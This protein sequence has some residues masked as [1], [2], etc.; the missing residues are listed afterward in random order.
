MKLH[1]VSLGVLALLSSLATHAGAQEVRRPY[2]VQLAD[3][4]AASYTGGV[5][6]LPATKPAP[7]RLLSVT[8]SDVQAY[9][10]YLERK[11]AG[12]L[13][14]VAAA[15]LTHKYQLVF[16]GFAALLTDSELRALRKDA[17][18]AAIAADE[19]REPVT[20][21]TP[22]FLGLDRVPGGLWSQLGG[23]SMAG[24]GIVIGLIDTGIWPEN[25]SFADR[26]LPDGS[27]SFDPAAA[28]AYGAPPAS[29]KGACQAGEG[30]TAAHCNNKLIGAR[31]FNAGFL[32]GGRTLHWSDFVS[33]RDS[34]GG[35][36]AHGGHGTHTASTAGGNNGVAASVG[37]IAMGTVS[38]M[39]PHARLAMYKV[40][41]TF[42]EEGSADGTGS[43]N[44]CYSSDSVA[45]IESAVADGVNVINYSISGSQTSVLDP[46]EIAFFG[47][48]NAGVFV[49]ASA[50]NSGPANAVSHIAPWLTTVAAGTH[51][52]LNA[53]KA[54]TG[55]GASYTGASLNQHALTNI[56]AISAR[57]AGLVP[58]ASLNLEDQVARTLCFTAADRAAFGGSPAAALDPA[59]ASGKIV[60]CE[61]GSSAR[62]D[63][64]RAVA[65]AGG[66]GMVLAD[67]GGGLVAEVHS[68][69]TVH[70]TAAD[71]K[72][73]MSYLAGSAAPT[74]S[75]SA[76]SVQVSSA[77][78]PQTAGFSSR[79]PNRAQPDILKPDLIAPGAD[80][81]AGVT[82]PKTEEQRNAI[83]AGSVQPEADWSFYSGTSM[84]SPHVAGLAA[85]LKQK[86]PL[87]SPAAIK[88]SLMTS[89]ATTY[90]DGVSG[91]AHGRL[92]W[93]QGAGH[94][95]PNSAADPGLVYELGTLDYNRFLCGIGAILPSSCVTTGSL[96][97]HNL[98]L[99]SLTAANVLG[100]LTLGRRVTN[101]G[102][103]TSTY[104]ASASL[105]GFDVVVT[106]ASL[107]LAPGQ[108]AS[109]SV[110]LTRSS[111]PIDTWSYG[112]LEW[113]DGSHVVR[114]PLSA[115]GVILSVPA[116]LNSTAASGNLVFGIG[117]GVSGKLGA[118]KGGLMPAR[119]EAQ[120]VGVSG[121]ADGGVA[122]CMGGGSAGVT[123]TPLAIPAGTLV[124]R[125]TLADVDTSGF[126]GGHS[127]DLDLMLLDAAGNLVG[128]SGGASANEKITLMAPAPGSYRICVIGFDP[129]GG[130]ASYTMSSWVLGS[131]D[132][133]GAFK[134]SMPSSAFL[135]GTASAAASWSG[136]AGGQ[137]YLGAL[138]YLVNGIV[139]GATL[140]EVDTSDAV[141]T[142]SVSRSARSAER[143]D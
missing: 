79:G 16:N 117:T 118:V 17:G 95:V 119:R 111:A 31:Y 84:S 10:G 49:A 25:R 132:S 68:V 52:R 99:P 50:G 6:G 32:A 122:E 55:A 107:T 130:S 93:G 121:A 136:L 21:F 59:R 70:L 80:I 92:P 141:P 110:G 90:D 66:V 102:A 134:V 67:N 120:R 125:L 24:D 73:I 94:V 38:G 133:G 5:A 14:K 23:K 65:E 113:R 137:H 47:A 100:K 33:P 20:N 4:P 140:V 42:V 115:K 77:A 30:F 48:S 57:D 83:A 82:P 51:N 126:A 106:P 56:A 97:P 101:V 29:W 81:L 124:A 112:A 58:F 13:A 85:M 135:G 72:A 43:R 71:A 88:S 41:W 39:A 96:A 53:A 76:F 69:P 11:Q 26:A 109:F 1:P 12:V 8:G 3:Q 116:T 28:L 104:T 98:N 128:Y 143:R 22:S 44:A 34:V 105:P 142:S 7:G 127:D 45:A 123:V 139:Q 60:L 54:T 89:A 64:S 87:W 138:Q 19:A 129:Y 9:L 63:K 103:S 36:F 15:R 91:I 62:V 131:A 2:I 86:H 78:A 114:S 46:V 108:Q 37:G 18:V 74:L 35:P 61:R 75:I 40:C 27:P